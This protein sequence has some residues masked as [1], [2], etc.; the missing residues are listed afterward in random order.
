MLTMWLSLSGLIVYLE[1]VYHFSGFG[2]I[3]DQRIPLSIAFHADGDTK[4]FDLGQ[5]IDPLFADRLQE[6][7][8]VDF[9]LDPL[10]ENIPD[11]FRIRFGHINGENGTDGLEFSGTQDVA[12]LLL[13]VL[14]QPVQRKVRGTDT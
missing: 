9:I 2:F 11:L 7:A 1:I 5:V 4:S 3:N 12:H 10:S 6:N 14:R 8:P 13:L